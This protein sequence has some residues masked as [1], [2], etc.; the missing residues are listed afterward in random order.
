ML[1]FYFPL[2]CK[3]F[4]VLG[5]LKLYLKLADIVLLCHCVPIYKTSDMCLS[6]SSDMWM[7]LPHLFIYIVVSYTSPLLFCTHPAGC[8]VLL[9][10]VVLG[11]VLVVLPRDGSA[12]DMW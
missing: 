5:I 8:V 3:I 11:E 7:V 12:A 2:H 10:L 1:T 6:E 9:H 4:V